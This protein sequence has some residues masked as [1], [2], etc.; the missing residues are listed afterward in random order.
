[1]KKTAFFVRGWVQSSK[2]GRIRGRG[3]DCDG[4]PPK[5][6]DGTSAFGGDV[7]DSAGPDRIV[8]TGYVVVQVG[9][10]DEGNDHGFH[11]F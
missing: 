8:E 10:S 7:F 11:L 6:D 3:A 9:G 4:A 2:R 1:V 5:A